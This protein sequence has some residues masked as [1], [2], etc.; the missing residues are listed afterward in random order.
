MLVDL[1]I[2][3]PQESFDKKAL[4]EDLVKLEDT[5]SICHTLGYT[6]VALNFTVNHA[7]KFP[8]NVKELN[9]MDIKER[10]KTFIENTGMKIY[11]RITLIIDDPS[12]GQS[13]AKISQAYDIIAAMPISEKGITLATTN[14]DIDLL[15]FDYS[16]RLPVFLKHKSICGCVKRGVK[17]EI[18]YAY[19]LRDLQSR[20]QFISNARSVIRSS[21]SR[22]I[23]VSSGAQNSLECRNIIGVTSLIKTLGLESDKCGKAMGQLAS[24]VLLNGRLRNKSYKQTI[25]VGGDVSN[26]V[27]DIEG[28]DETKLVKIV[29]RNADSEISR[30]KKKMSKK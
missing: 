29:K 7:S 30:D 12:K 26:V 18:P 25:V 8:N 9:P 24:L 14:L 27:D 11:S 19:A 10:F 13:L 15:T 17:V 16:Q 28:I 1:N 3:W 21:R 6:H 4:P 23:V 5:L 22:G 2:K 20:R